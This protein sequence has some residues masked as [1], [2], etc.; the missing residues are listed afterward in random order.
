VGG[1]RGRGLLVLGVWRG[2]DDIAAGRGG[3]NE[4]CVR[5]CTAKGQKL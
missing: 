5:A 1:A 3:W 2:G 4:H